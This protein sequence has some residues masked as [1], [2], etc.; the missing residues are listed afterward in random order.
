MQNPVKPSAH[1][2]PAQSTLLI[3]D[4][5]EEAQI[6]FVMAGAASDAIR[7]AYDAPGRAYVARAYE[8]R[9]GVCHLSAINC[10]SAA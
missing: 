7:S 5:I 4:F 8:A 9:A 1:S 3:E 2:S 10:L 6:L